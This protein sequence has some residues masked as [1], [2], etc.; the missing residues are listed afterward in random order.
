[1]LLLGL[2][3]KLDMEGGG[4]S[5]NFPLCVVACIDSTWTFATLVALV[6]SNYVYAFVAKL[7]ASVKE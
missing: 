4:F 1:M 6:L 5:G 7:I 2:F 3:V